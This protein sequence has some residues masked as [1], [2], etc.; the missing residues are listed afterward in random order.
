MRNEIV[1]SSLI[2]FYRQ[3]GPPH[4][5]AIRIRDRDTDELRYAATWQSGSQRTLSIANN[6]AL[7]PGANYRLWI[8][9]SK[10]MR[11]LGQA[12]N[13]EAYA[14]QQ[15]SPGSGV[16]ELQLPNLAQDNDIVFDLSSIASLDQPDGANDGYRQYIFDSANIDFTIPADLSIDGSEPAVLSLSFADMSDFQI[17][18]NPATPVDW[19]NGGWSGYENEH[20]VAADSGGADCQIH[21]FVATDSTATP[22]FGNID[23]RQATPTP[24]PPAPMPRGGGGNALWLCL[25]LLSLGPR[26]GDPVTKP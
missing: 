25:L 23:C 26:F 9:F 6:G 4:I 3:A 18:A 13:A 19:Q 24:P 21:P 14:G 15:T 2:G 20:G 7:L 12:G 1:S 17:D 11:M 22:P 5:T 10:P 8:A 16:A